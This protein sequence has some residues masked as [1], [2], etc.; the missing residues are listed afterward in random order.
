MGD[1]N[2]SI[3]LRDAIFALSTSNHDLFLKNRK[4]DLLKVEIGGAITMQTGDNSVKQEQTAQIPWVE[5]DSAD[6]AY[7]TSWEV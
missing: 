7:L 1:Y 2:D 3:S 6:G 4:G 5:V